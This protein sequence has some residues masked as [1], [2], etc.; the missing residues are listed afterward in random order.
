M[1]SLQ[2]HIEVGNRLILALS[3]FL[4][5]I[6][7]RTSTHGIT[8]SQLKLV[9]LLP[10]LPNLKTPSQTCTEALLL[11]NLAFDK[12]TI[13]NNKVFFP[14]YS[15]TIFIFILDIIRVAFTFHIPT[16]ILSFNT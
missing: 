12:L 10:Q 2:P 9:G 5:F 14:L 16:R 8:L 13:N 6:Q 3:S 1:G 7:F 11:A 4:I 15:N